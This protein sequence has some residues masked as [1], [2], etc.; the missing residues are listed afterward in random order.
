MLDR[1]PVRLTQWRVKSADTILALF[2]CCIAALMG[3]GSPLSAQPILIEPE[4]LVLKGAP[5]DTVTGL[6]TIKNNKAANPNDPA[7]NRLSMTITGDDA[8][9]DWDSWQSYFKTKRDEAEQAGELFE[10][11]QRLSKWDPADILSNVA[12]APSSLSL[13]PGESITM[14]VMMGPFPMLEEAG[15]QQYQYTPNFY[16][17]DYS[18]YG[19][20]YIRLEITHP[21]P[22]DVTDA[23]LAQ[24]L[25]IELNKFF[26]APK[27]SALPASF[28][29]GDPIRPYH[30]S[31]LETVS[32]AG[33][34]GPLVT[35][36]DALKYAE[37][38]TSLNLSN[39]DI[40]SIEVLRNLKSLTAL[41]LD[42]NQISDI[43][44]LANLDQLGQLYIRNN[45][46][47]FS[48][49]STASNIIDQLRA[50]GTNVVHLDQRPGMRTISSWF[51]EVNLP[52]E[53]SSVEAKT[54]PLQLPNVLSFAMG[55]DPLSPSVEELPSA[56]RS[57]TGTS[58]A[59]FTYR[60]KRDL[61][62]IGIRTAIEASGDLKTWTEVIPDAIRVISDDGN[63]VQVVEA[64]F[65]DPTLEQL[66][67]R[68]KVLP[69]N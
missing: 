61:K 24:L 26:S 28:S 19:S 22:I 27:N 60:Y 31:Y 14:L 11:N 58:E 4:V 25:D 16:P 23:G 46:I 6:I 49:G 69:D 7:Y 5:G 47:D 20:N 13:D 17:E 41:Y 44:P 35:Q 52:G 30:I 2:T 43:G 64:S 36:I 3:L 32:V 56:G 21:E 65:S 66:F 10:Y 39:H 40:T 29:S 51:S 63:G 38:L 50:N 33:F 54:G 62:A 68:L 59:A 9:Y 12:G 57:S 55:V 45:W 67:F 48:P 42:G 37:N 15:Q 34:D 1:F 18:V 53:S 8:F